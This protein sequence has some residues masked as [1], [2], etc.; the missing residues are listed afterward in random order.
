MLSSLQTLSLEFRSPQS[1]PDR[2]SPSLPP[3][4]RSILP[5]LAEFRFKGVIEYLEELMTHIDTPQLS[6]MDINFFN[7]IDFDCP[8]LAP[9]H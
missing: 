7:Q 1:R 3:P 6:Q 4:K 2:E 8:R 5:A 9:I